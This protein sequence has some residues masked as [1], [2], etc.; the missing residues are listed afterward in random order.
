MGM[1]G[2]EDLQVEQEVVEA[3]LWYTVMKTH[4]KRSKEQA[5]H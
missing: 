4:C 3:L 1:D 2:K 5:E